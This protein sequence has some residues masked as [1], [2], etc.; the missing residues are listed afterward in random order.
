MAHFAYVVDGVVENVEVVVNAVM[1]N[2]EGVEVEAIGQEFLGLLYG[3]PP[4]NFIQ[5]SYNGNFRGVYPGMGYA[6]DALA[7]VFIAPEPVGT[8]VEVLDEAV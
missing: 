6:Y 3:L 2:G 1:T 8:P 4:E 7:D 5:C